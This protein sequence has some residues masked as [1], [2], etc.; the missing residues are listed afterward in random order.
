MSFTPKQYANALYKIL[1]EAKEEQFSDVVDSF[2]RLMVENGDSNN[3]EEIVNNFQ[4]IWN[5]NK[6]IVEAE[7][8]TVHE[9]NEGMMDILRDYI[10]T[11]TGASEVFLEQKV[12]ESILGGVVIKYKD[13]ILDASLKKE[14][15]ELKKH[16]KK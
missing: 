9:L 16:I 4:E 7:I 1:E 15:Q 11:T 13:K 14:I 5:D 8:I 3:I 6:N 2:A 10:K 12:D